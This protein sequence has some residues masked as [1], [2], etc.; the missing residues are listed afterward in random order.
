M[1]VLAL[2]ILFYIVDILSKPGGNIPVTAPAVDL[3][4]FAFPGHVKAEI[5]NVRMAARTGVIAVGGSLKACLVEGVVVAG[6]T[7]PGRP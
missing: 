6:L 5:G 1:A 7:V 4:G 2:K 3:S